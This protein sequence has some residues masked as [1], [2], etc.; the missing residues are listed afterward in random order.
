VTETHL[1]A[2]RQHYLFHVRRDGFGARRAAEISA[3]I[4]FRHRCDK[5]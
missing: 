3:F 1:S 4:F 2:N 5:M